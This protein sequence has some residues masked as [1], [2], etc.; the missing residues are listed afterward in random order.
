MLEVTDQAG[1]VIRRFTSSDKPEHLDPTSLPHPTYWIRPTQILAATKGHHRF[2]WDL[3]HEPPRGARRQFAI[4]A[5]Q[6]RTPSGPHGPFVPPGQYR[7][8]LTVD[9]FV[10][11]SSLT[12]R[13]D[14]RVRLTETEL[15]LQTELSMRCYS[16]YNI[17]QNLREAIDRVAEE[18]SGDRR[19]AL[20]ELR[21]NGAPELPDL[22][23]GSI[24]QASIEDETIVDLQ[25]KLLHMLSL[26]QGADAPP[27]TQAQEAVEELERTLEGLQRRSEALRP[28]I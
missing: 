28:E 3:R 15:D 8:R 7:V 9:G 23:Y 12:V 24:Y 22:L 21:G 10:S 20:Q 26:L 4:A 18:S 19:R 27:T 25:F 14:P 2:V 13:L 11:E 17:A 6:L 1:E 16:G 5:V